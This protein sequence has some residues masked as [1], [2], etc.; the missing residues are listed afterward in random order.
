MVVAGL[1]GSDRLDS[2]AWFLEAHLTSRNPFSV[3][4]VTALLQFGAAYDYE[5]L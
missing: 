2:H 5:H 1:P 3:A 4:D